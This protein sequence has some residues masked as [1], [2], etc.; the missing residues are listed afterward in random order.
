MSDCVTPDVAE[1]LADLGR[2]AAKE[3]R[4]A[5]A[6]RPK[7]MQGVIAALVA[8]RGFAATGA[9]QELAEAWREA[10]GETIARFTCLGAV[11]RGVLEVVV[12]NSAM[13]QEVHF[14]KPRLLAAMQAA[15]PQAR[16]TA[17]RLRVGRV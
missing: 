3:Q 8:K 17:L 4:R 5:F 1:R 13:M 16:L 14:H 2:R 10:A 9:N 15:A 12:A 7:P 11:R 6:R